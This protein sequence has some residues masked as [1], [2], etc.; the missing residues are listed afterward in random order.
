M[1]ASGRILAL[2][3]GERRI[4]VAVSDPLQILARPLTVIQRASR[5]DDF[6]RI[7]RL[8]GEQGA[9]RIVCG[10]PLS[11][12]GSEGPQGR[13]V[14]RYA[15]ALQEAVKVPVELWDESYS[16]VDAEEKM[17]A[18]QPRLSPRERRHW[19]DAVAAAVILQGYLNAQSQ[20]AGTAPQ[21]PQP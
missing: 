18:T 8:A 13:R 4:G 16:T 9:I 11:L 7:G 1:S 14:R 3:I 5:A 20:A 2:D 12:D 17:Q 6:A 19:V 15:E 21:D 10:Y